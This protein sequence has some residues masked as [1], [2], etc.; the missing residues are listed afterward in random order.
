MERDELNFRP[1]ILVAAASVAIIMALPSASKSQS[2]GDSITL[3]VPVK[4]Q[5][6]AHGVSARIECSIFEENTGKGRFGEGGA[7]IELIN[8]GVDTIATVIAA[9]NPGRNFTT[10]RK[11]FCRLFLRKGDILAGN[12]G[13]PIEVRAATGGVD[14]WRF[15]EPGTPFVRE[16]WGDLPTQ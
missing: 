16:F 7:S 1:Q 11:Y 12:T 8:G 9:P 4:L 15:A 5:R 6:I 3:N 10:A 14:D 2:E 13:N